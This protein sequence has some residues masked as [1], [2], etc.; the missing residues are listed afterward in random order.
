MC[1]NSYCQF[2][3][4]LLCYDIQ[5][6]VL[7]SRHLHHSQILGSA[8]LALRLTEIHLEILI[9][10]LFIFYLSYFRRLFSKALVVSYLIFTLFDLTSII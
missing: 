1:L 10:F 2:E 7:L 3:K 8:K 6:L 4:L 9:V 5:S